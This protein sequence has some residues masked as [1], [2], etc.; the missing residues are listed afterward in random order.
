V[1]VKKEDN[2]SDSGILYAL[3]ELSKMAGKSILEVYD[4]KDFSTVLKDD[5]SPLT[6]AD[7]TSHAI[8]IDGL[9][10]LTPK[11]PILSEESKSIPYEIRKQWKEYWL[12]DPLDGT[13]E[14]IKRN[15]EFTVNIALVKNDEPVLGV[16][17]AP[18][19]DVCYF[20]ETGKGAFKKDK[21]GEITKIAV[22]HDH[23]NGLKAVASRS[24]Q[25]KEEEAFFKKLGIHEYISMG[26]S[27]KFCLVAEGKAHVYPRF[28]PTREWDTAAAQCVAM[29]AGAEV[30]D[31]N[32]KLLKYNKND[33]LNPY[34]IVSSVPQ[35]IWKRALTEL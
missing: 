33:L 35:K 11:I 27:L 23:S 18:V 28:L 3:I 19:L 7:T 21:N 25:G 4:S 22:Q 17:Y 5:R 34:F 15:G 20:A 13:K 2:V 31:L 9:K 26:S 12:V 32:G 16:V 29:E 1:K 6:S 30:S 8:I 10:K 24:H 14:F